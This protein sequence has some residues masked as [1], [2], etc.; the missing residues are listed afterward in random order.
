MVAVHPA[1]PDQIENDVIEAI[2]SVGQRIEAGNRAAGRRAG[3]IAWTSAIKAEL[4][5]LADRY[6]Y[7]PCAS[8]CGSPEWLYDITWRDVRGAYLYDVPLVLESEW[9]LSGVVQDFKKLLVARARH[10]VMIFELPH[11]DASL[12]KSSRRALDELIDHIGQCS[13]SSSGDRYLF[14][15]W[16]YGDSRRDFYFEVVVAA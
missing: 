7:Q 10:R 12:P 16:E 4:A 2:R 6:Q 11:R 3:N 1:Q 15:V 14:A 5:E 9:T 8:G 13:F